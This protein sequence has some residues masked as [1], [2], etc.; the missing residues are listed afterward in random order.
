VQNLSKKVDEEI[1]KNRR[2]GKLKSF[3]GN[4]ENLL[5]D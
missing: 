2:A 3:T 5:G 1:H 4:I